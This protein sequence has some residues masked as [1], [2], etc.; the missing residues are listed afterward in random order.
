MAT[1]CYDNL[2]KN[3]H[4]YVIMF[5]FLLYSLKEYECIHSAIHGRAGGIWRAS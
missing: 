4:R 1:D 5:I 3:V 2:M